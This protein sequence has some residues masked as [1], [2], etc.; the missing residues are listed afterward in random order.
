MSEWIGEVKVVNL[1]ACC[2]NIRLVVGVDTFKVV[3][4]IECLAFL[5]LTPAHFC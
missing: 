3:V 1:A 2:K 4:G 5:L